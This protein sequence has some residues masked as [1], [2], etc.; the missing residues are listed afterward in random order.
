[1]SVKKVQD[2]IAWQKSLDLV[3]DV[4]GAS[5]DWPRDERFGLTSQIRR[6]VVSVPSNFAEGQDRFST[7]EFLRHLSIAYGSLMETH[8]QLQIAHKLGYLEQRTL[9]ALV[10][11][12][13]E[14]GRIV[15]GLA[16]KLEEKVDRP[17]GRSARK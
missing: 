9:D 10:E 15:N 4:Y 12:I 13:D 14:V 1:M 2:L 11:K 3:K 6:A 7:A 17:A 5:K 16:R 8:T